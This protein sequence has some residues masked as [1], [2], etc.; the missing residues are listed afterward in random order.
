MK[1]KILFL[2]V[3]SSLLFKS[4]GQS[5]TPNLGYCQSMFTFANS[6]GD[7]INS[8]SLNNI[9]NIS[10][11]CS[12]VPNYTNF[13]GVPA[14]NT[15]LLVGVTYTITIGCQTNNPGN[16]RAWIDY[17]GDGIFTTSEIIGTANNLSGL[18]SK[19]FT[20]TVPTSAVSGFTILR[21]EEVYGS[22]NISPIACD[23][24]YSFGEEEDYGITIPTRPPI[25]M[26]TTAIISPSNGCSLDS[27]F[28][29][30]TFF[31]AGTA[32]IIGYT[33]NFDINSGNSTASE[34][35]NHTVAPLAYDTYT[36]LAKGYVGRL[37]PDTITVFCT[38]AGDNISIDDAVIEYFNNY[39]S[40][41]TFPFLENFNSGSLNTNARKSASNSTAASFVSPIA[42]NTGANGFLMTGSSTSA[43]WT[44]P[45]TGQQFNLNAGFS[46]TLDYC[47]DARNVSA[48]CG[49]RLRFDLKQTASYANS[50]LNSSF[51]ILINGTQISPNYSPTTTQND[52]FATYTFNLSPYLGTTFDLTFESRNRLDS[53]HAYPGDNAFLDN[54]QISPYPNVDI[55][56][57]KVLAPTSGCGHGLTDTV[58]VLL[59]TLGCDSL[60]AGTQIPV[61]Y[62]LN[63]GTPIS[64]TITLTKNYHRGDSIY[65]NFSTTINALTGA[66]YTLDISVNYGADGDP[67]NNNVSGSFLSQPTISLFPWNEGFEGNQGNPPLWLTAPVVGNNGW[68][69]LNGSMISPGLTAHGGSH[70]AYFSYTNGNGSEADLFSPCF[71][72]STLDIPLLRFFVGQYQFSSNKAWVK[73]YA[74]LDGGI[75]YNQAD[76][77][78]IVSST[79]VFPGVWQQVQTCLGAYS[80]QPNVKIKFR[81]NPFNGISNNTDIG[82]DDVS[83]LE[84]K[85]SATAKI[86]S[87]TICVGSTVKVSLSKSLFGRNYFLTNSNGTKI[88]PIKKGTGSSLSFTSA[89]LTTSTTI[90]VGYLDSIPYAYCT[91]YL[92]DS[93]HVLVLPYAVANAG[94]DTFVCTGSQT[95]LT[96]SGGTRY[97]WTPSSGLNNAFTAN[98]ICKPY[99]T[100][101]YILKADTL[102][103]CATYDTVVIQLRQSPIANAGATTLLCLPSMA[104]V[105][106]GGSP[107][108]SSG[109]G[110]YTYVWTPLTGLNFSNIANPLASPTVTTTYSILVKDQNKCVATASVVVN[111][112]PLITHTLSVTKILCN[113]GTG[114]ACINVNGGTKPYHYSWGSPT[115]TNACISGLTPNPN[116]YKIYVSDSLFCSIQDSVLITQPSQMYVLLNPHTT[117]CGQCDGFVS[118]VVSGGTTPYHYL[119]SNSTTNDSLLN[120]CNGAYHLMVTDSNGCK[121]TDSTTVTGPNGS[122]TFSVNAGIDQQ[123]C[124]GEMTYIGGTPTLYGGTLPYQFVWTPTNA[125]SGAALSNPLANPTVSTTY[126]VKAT[127]A[128]GCTNSD[129]MILVVHP[130]PVANAGTDITYCKLVNATLGAPSQAGLTYS[131]Q[132][133]TGL[134]KTN[135]AN[136]IVNITATITYTLTVTNSFG[137]ID[138]NQVLV[139]VNLEPLTN[140]GAD[141]L[142][143]LGGST[144]LN[145]SGAKYYTWS[146]PTGLNATIGSTVIANPSSTITYAV[147]G[148]DSLGCS[149]TDSVT[150]FVVN[151][152]G[153]DEIAEKLSLKIYPNPF[154]EIATVEYSLPN[155]EHVNVMLFNIS[156]VLEQNI[157][158]E[159]Q[160]AGYH[161]IIL[162]ADKL[163]SG[164]YLLL[165]KTDEGI[166]VKKLMKQQ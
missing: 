130:N 140:A 156:G 29:T 45:G 77:I 81:S 31:N 157:L 53:I 154:N 150:V 85:D 102:G 148:T 43:T 24:F 12:A 165:I 52:P 89:A 96:G 107:T 4:Y 65:Y 6:T 15:T 37:G 11:P 18:T 152:N 14:A 100:T 139:T 123:I 20:F 151:P 136:P 3:F 111:V 97:E 48:N 159:K 143:Y 142:I 73:V 57:V 101:T 13:S 50:L 147:K 61:S 28:V 162:N 109:S 153:M 94:V 126:H 74:S 127:D 47:V 69:I 68:S 124:L 119:W 82:I 141:A 116:R 121:S 70:I 118:S 110:F 26:A 32:P 40:V 41:S 83:I 62:V 75:T 117:N 112:D 113:G 34:F 114:S 160:T 21:I 91:L 46:Q 44:K 27:V 164:N 76:S 38:K 39:G 72:F 59:Q 120:A 134:S 86:N 146:P 92:A 1:K 51:R 90:K 9:N 106:I 125:L 56:A 155:A 58:K 129:S 122:T 158:N 87:D 17:N 60:L 132:P 30:A 19:P 103:Y 78:N 54:V 67:L 145:A 71:D 36:F 79:A 115:Q 55:A 22:G 88:T 144:V 66:L 135:V 2:L 131:W 128:N 33:A 161:K 149:A 108:A 80:H 133:S 63:G 49:L 84:G 93:F 99:F 10:G 163:S 95:V 7:Y 105:Q 8:V 166:V 138:S 35:V 23:S 5:T 42:A 104:N 16:L 137:C 25:D 98:P 64:E